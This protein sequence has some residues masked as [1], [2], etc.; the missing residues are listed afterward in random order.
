MLGRLRL[1]HISGCVLFP[2]GNPVLRVYLSPVIQIEPRKPKTLALFYFDR[3]RRGPF[4]AGDDPSVDYVLGHEEFPTMEE[5]I[6][7]GLKQAGISRCGTEGKSYRGVQKVTGAES[8]E[9]DG[10]CGSIQAL[11]VGA[12]WEVARRKPP[13]RAYISVSIEASALESGPTHHRSR[14]E[15]GSTT[16]WRMCVR[17]HVYVIC[18]RPSALCMTAG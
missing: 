1:S 3:L 18:R 6:A 4:H 14:S 8:D 13:H 2:N 12:F 16:R 17:L 11:K 5:L 9:P 7:A 15:S 10:T